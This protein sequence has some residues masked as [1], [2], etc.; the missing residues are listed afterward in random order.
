ML[1]KETT[2]GPGKL[3]QAL[4]ITKDMDSLP[5]YNKLGGLWIEDQNIAIAKSEI[6]AGPRVGLSKL[7][8]SD[9][10][11]KWRFTLKN[12]KFVS[13][14]KVVKYPEEWKRL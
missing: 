14:P 6:I 1:K 5:L 12:N 8:G 2:N 3:C 4:S 7:T 9:A 11:R 13:S 10:H